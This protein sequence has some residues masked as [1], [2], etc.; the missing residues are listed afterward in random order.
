MC[1]DSR[2]GSTCQ[3][4]GDT[5]TPEGHVTRLASGY[6]YQPR[7][8]GGISPEPE[9]YKCNTI[10]ILVNFAKIVHTT[11][12]SSLSNICK[13]FNNRILE[14]IGSLGQEIQQQPPS[15]TWVLISEPLGSKYW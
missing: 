8:I 15:K 10:P 3:Y 13:L 2:R 5:D 11:W 14:Y 9:L 1:G 7:R 6:L 4:D 12:I